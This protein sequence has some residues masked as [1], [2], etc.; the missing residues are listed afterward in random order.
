MAKNKRQERAK[1]YADASRREQEH[2]TGFRS[3]LNLPKGINFWQ[4]NTKEDANEIDIVP[5]E[6]GKSSKKFRKDI[7]FAEPGDLYYERT[8]FT[9]RDVGPEEKSVVCPKATFGQPCPIC[10]YAAKA[11]QE[12]KADAETLKALRPKERQLFLVHDHAAPKKGVQLWDVSFFLFGANL[13]EKI[14]KASEK[15]KEKFQQFF[16]DDEEGSSLRVT[17]KEKSSPFGKFSEY[18]VDSFEQREE[19][20]A[21]E[22]MNH[23]YCLDD[24]VVCPDYDELKALFLGEATDD[25]DEAEEEEEKPARGRKPKDEEPEEEEEEPEEEEEESEAPEFEKGMTVSGVYRKKK[26]EGEIVKVDAKKKQIHVDIGEDHPR[27]V[28]FDDETL[29]I[30]EEEEQEEEEPEEEEEE[31]PRRRTR[32]PK[33]EEDDDALE[34]EEPEEEEEEEEETPRRRGGK[35]TARGRGRR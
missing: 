32:K 10:E 29:E 14:K 33:D 2:K 8:Y 23:G 31:T 3:S 21:D 24:F 17:A 13:D 7:T 5:Y 25:D 28:D 34:D 18:F 22:V 30:I 6:V 15:N 11:G 1:R 26:Y 12:V 27:I 20:L 4:P 19:P 9:H 35:D 16:R